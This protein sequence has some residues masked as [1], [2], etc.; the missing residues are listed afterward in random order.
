[1]KKSQKQDLTGQIF[2]RLKVVAQDGW[3]IT[4]STGDRTAKWQCVCDCGNYKVVQVSQLRNGHTKS[5]GCYRKELRISKNKTQIAC[6]I[7]PKQDAMNKIWRTH[8][9]GAKARELTP[10]DKTRYFEIAINNCVT[11]GIE[12]EIT[13]V[14]K[15]AYLTL[16][17]THNM[18]IDQDFADAKVIYCNGIDRIDSAKGY[19]DGNMQPMCQQCNIAKSDRTQEEF[20]EHILRAAAHISARRNKT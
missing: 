19:V 14:A 20:E 8:V 3:Y 5:C 4:P 7:D 10:L 13:L 2:G 6:R 9:T 16:C 17:K 18:V 12:P 11:C 15:T 1:M